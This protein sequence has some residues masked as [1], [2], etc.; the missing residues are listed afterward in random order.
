MTRTKAWSTHIGTALYRRSGGRLAGGTDDA[1]VLLLT[2]P[3]RRTGLP[4][5]ACVRTIPH[6]GDYLV[7]GTGAGSPTDPDWFRNLRHA[8][9]GEGQIGGQRFRFTARELTGEDREHVWHD[10][11]LRR[12]PKVARYARRAG[13]PIPVARLTVLDTVAEDEGGQDAVDR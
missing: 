6:D 5:S 9:A 12:L 11:V 2:V 4:R 1:P 8:G 10:V 13:R 7:W 3:G